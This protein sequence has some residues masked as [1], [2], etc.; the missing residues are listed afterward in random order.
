MSRNE[1]CLYNQSWFSIVFC[2]LM[3]LFIQ[4]EST[5]TLKQSINE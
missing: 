3:N 4:N 1:R 5:I 2:S